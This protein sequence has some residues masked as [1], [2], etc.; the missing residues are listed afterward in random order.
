MELFLAYSNR[1]KTRIFSI[2]L[3]LSL[4]FCLTI[5]SSCNNIGSFAKF[6]QDFVSDDMLVMIYVSG[7]NSLNN[8][9]ILDINSME[10]GLFAVTGNSKLKVVVLA[11]KQKSY[12][13]ESWTG[14]R[15]YEILPKYAE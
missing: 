5:F 8:E 3:C 2:L 6:G 11:D 4:F 7:A 9:V 13:S 10:R 12:G 15:L 1:Q 14:T